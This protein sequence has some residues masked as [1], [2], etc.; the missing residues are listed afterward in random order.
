ME[1]ICFSRPKDER[2]IHPSTIASVCAEAGIGPWDQSWVLGHTRTHALSFPHTSART[3]F[4][5]PVPLPP[6]NP[7]VPLSLSPAAGTVPRHAP[8][9]G[10]SAR[11]AW[12]ARSCMSW[13]SWPRT[14]LAAAGTP[15]SSARAPMRTETCARPESTQGSGG[16]SV[17]GLLGTRAERGGSGSLCSPSTTPRRRPVPW[18]LDL[19][20]H[21]TGFGA[22]NPKGRFTYTWPSHGLGAS[23]ANA[24]PVQ[25]Q[26]ASLN[27]PASLAC[28]GDPLEVSMAAVASNCCSCA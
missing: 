24:P 4:A 9:T 22:P 15:P 7:R 11:T 18:A 12:P 13:R 25:A 10:A 5:L 16:A 17:T 8:P 26:G 23:E 28:Q 21:C 3:M 14:P 20:T 19:S 27:A 6:L 2:H 1:W